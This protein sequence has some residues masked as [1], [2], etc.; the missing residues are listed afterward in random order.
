MDKISSLEYAVNQRFEEQLLQFRC[1]EPT[2][3]NRGQEG[4][5][6]ALLPSV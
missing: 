1:L 2:S 3:A 6:V 4:F 5:K